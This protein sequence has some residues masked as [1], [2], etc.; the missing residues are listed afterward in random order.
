M[1]ICMYG[2]VLCVFEEGLNKELKDFCK[3]FICGWWLCLASLF[4]FGGSSLVFY[5]SINVCN[6]VVARVLSVALGGT[7][8]HFPYMMHSMLF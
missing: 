5:N 7:K 8:I 2:T 3:K 1:Q 6:I 4:L